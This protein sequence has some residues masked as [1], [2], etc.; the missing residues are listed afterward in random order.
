MLMPIA[1]L[2]WKHP[3][4]FMTLNI[5][6]LAALVLIIIQCLPKLYSNWNINMRNICFGVMFLG[7]L[8]AYAFYDTPLTN[9]RTSETRE[10]NQKKKNQQN[11]HQIV[12]D[13]KLMPS[14]HQGIFCFRIWKCGI[15][16]TDLWM[17]NVTTTIIN[18][19]MRINKSTEYSSL[20]RRSK[21][22]RHFRHVRYFEMI[23]SVL[24]AQ[25]RDLRNIFD[26]I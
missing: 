22:S 14:G 20:L 26:D 23:I 13:E 6:F 16:F 8:E 10:E 19:D 3:K 5:I 25:R 2:R 21:D 12:N 1:C 24:F 9:V 11:K 7:I 18:I 15:K 4:V 17:T